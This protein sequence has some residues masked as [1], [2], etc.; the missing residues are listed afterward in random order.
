MADRDRTA[1]SNQTVA[2]G[3]PAR[4]GPDGVSLPVDVV[5]VRDR[6]MLDN[7][8]EA[9]FGGRRQI[10]APCGRRDLLPIDELPLCLEALPFDGVH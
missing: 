4:L 8:T 9:T 10:I 5:G 2:T 1:D 6:R 7:R 3:S